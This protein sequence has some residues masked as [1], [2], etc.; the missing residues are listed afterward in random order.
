MRKRGNVNAHKYRI[1]PIIISFGLSLPS[2]NHIRVQCHLA[3]AKIL[4]LITMVQSSVLVLQ[5]SHDK[6]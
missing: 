2:S 6:C 4:L 3:D 5:H 1:G